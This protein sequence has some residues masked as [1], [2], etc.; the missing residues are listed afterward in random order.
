[1]PDTQDIMDSSECPDS[2]PIDFN[3]LESLNSGHPATLYTVF[4][5]LIA[6]HNDSDLVDT[7][8]P[9]QQDC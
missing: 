6:I 5:L 1:M 4:T 8:G 3:T 2:F 9:L 7:R